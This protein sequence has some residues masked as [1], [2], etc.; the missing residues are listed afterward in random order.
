MECA[1]FRLLN[2]D[3]LDD[4]P[5]SGWMYVDITCGMTF[6]LQLSDFVGVWSYAKRFSPPVVNWVV[7]S[8]MFLWFHPEHW[9][10]DSIRLRFFK[11]F[12]PPPTSTSH[13]TQP[14]WQPTS[15]HPG[16]RLKI[17]V[18]GFLDEAKNPL[19]IL[20]VCRWWDLIHINRYV[21]LYICIS[22]IRYVQYICFFEIYTDILCIHLL[23][24][25]CFSFVGL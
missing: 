3:I 5:L 15:R 9:G 7:V 12:F 22:V 20:M 6:Q 23:E 24:G 1:E 10:I 17:V 16:L 18:D 21:Y 8:N 2:W 14:K 4:F 13:V 11:G 25:P 19:L